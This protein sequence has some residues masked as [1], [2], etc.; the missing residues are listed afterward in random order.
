MASRSNLQAQV[1]TAADEIRRL[2]AAHGRAVIVIDGGLPESFFARLAGAPDIDWMLVII[3]LAGEW[4]GVDADAE[5]SLRRQI[6]DHLLMR[7]P[8]V[9]FHA[10]RGEAAN[11]RAVVSNY[12]HLL[13]T[14]RPDLAVLGPFAESSANKIGTADEMPP[15]AIVEINGRRAIALTSTAWRQIPL[16]LRVGD[17]R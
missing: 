13:A 16:V 9:E 3:F 2:I 1:E 7:V 14:K 8:I 4:L 5:E 10:P 6:I 11:P 17:D 15:V 12:A